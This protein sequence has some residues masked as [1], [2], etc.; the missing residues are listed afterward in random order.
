[1]QFGHSVQILQYAHLVHLPN[2]LHVTHILYICNMCMISAQHV[3]KLHIKMCHMCR[4]FV[5]DCKGSIPA[6]FSLY[7]CL[8]AYL[9][10]I[11]PKLWEE[12]MQLRHLLVEC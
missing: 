5:R 11:S 8:L 2:S 12:G 4:I 3:C 10:V 9:L 6:I 7:T 1:M